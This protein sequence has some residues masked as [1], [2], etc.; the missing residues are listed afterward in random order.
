MAALYQGVCYPTVEAARKTACSSASLSWGSGASSY[1]LDCT[2]SD[3]SA[4]HMDLC[5]RQDGG[6]C[7]ILQR[8][9][10]DF[11]ECDYAGGSGMAVDWLFIVLPIMAGLWGLKK[12]SN[13]FDHNPRESE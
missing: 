12:L 4:Q 2:S 9:Y 5:K 1:S 6:A 11:P 10:P 13:L 7:Q 3:F 8:P